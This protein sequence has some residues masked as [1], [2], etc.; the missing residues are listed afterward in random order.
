M[1]QD[2]R[3]A[4]RMILKAPA[5]SLV[6]ILTLA[7]GIGANTAIFSVVNAAM[8]RPLPFPN[9]QRLMSIFHVYKK[10]NLDRVT[11]YPAAYVYFKDHA[12]SF[13]QVAAFSGFRAPQNLTGGGDPER[14]HV[15]A[16][17]ASLFPALGT[18]PLL[19][20]AFTAE[21]DKPGAGRVAVLGYGLWNRRFGH[22]DRI[23][24]REITLDGA[25]YTV[26]GV[27]PKGFEFPEEAELWVPIAFT[28][29]Q[30]ANGS[31]YLQV[32][33]K[34]RPGVTY[35]QAQAEMAKISSEILASNGD[36]ANQ[37]GWSAATQPLQEASVSDV[38][39]ALWVLL[40]AVGCVLLI[41]CANVANLLLARAA[42]R[43][44]EIS[45]RSALGASRW[46][47]VRQL[48]SEGILLSL[49]G[50]TV[51]LLFG[52]LGLDLLLDTIPI[53]V[54]SYIR[55]EIDPAV[56][57]FTFT[58][59]IVTGIIF[60]AIPALQLTRSNVNESL[61]EG[62]RSSAA[63]TRQAVRT[64]I[65][66]AQLAFAMMLLVAAGL[67]IKTF[68][69]IQQSDF[70]FNSQ[71]LLTFRTDLPAAKYKEPAQ[72][73]A[74][75][76][77]LIERTR[78]LRG[79]T[80]AAITS[81]TPLTTNMTSIF[82]IEGKT[83]SVRPHVHVASIGSD[84]FK[85]M[86]IPVISGRPFTDADR[87]GTT[88]VA[89]IDEKTKRAYFGDEVPIGKKLTFDFEGSQEKRV[90]R[91]IVGVVGGVKHRSPLENETKGE[92][93]LPFAQE[94]EKS[95]IVAMRTTGNPLSLADAARREVLNVD[96]LQPVQ[97]LQTM[98]T[99]VDDF[100]AQ[101]RFN[102]IL[103]GT[104]GALAL[105]LSGIGVYGVMAYTVTQRTHEFGIRMALGASSA[106]VLR[107]VLNQA[108]KIT[109]VGLAVG[110]VGAF[111]A[112]RALGSMLFGV[113]ASDPATFAGI[114]LLLATI[115][116]L[117]S[118]LPARRA[119]KVDPVIAL[120]YE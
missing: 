61:K 63:S 43:Q 98:D 82:Q 109:L 76:D 70:G 12:S 52:Y 27:M 112:T 100:V 30:L 23:V 46:R 50:G 3:F 31:E 36:T 45:I 92:V 103:L 17:T 113:K 88:P 35:P 19:G 39:T 55:V 5:F 15:V 13:E 73:R 107:V 117:A 41:A 106:D 29:E 104:F 42:A 74:F 68:V 120:R 102:M 97:D 57:L 26:I 71:G 67:L 91:T 9:S 58:L 10:L 49:L 4:L 110:L 34:L 115:A 37:Y 105:I 119:T 32:I 65:V 2:F 54:P 114:A 69:R 66:V 78:N 93:F 18:P 77:Q 51:G 96:P 87:E 21:E 33:A 62:G 95:M 14:I 60:S 118:Y 116:I 56:L 48:L 86:Q 64:S 80:S 108:L 24:G 16:A 11:V 40:S 53:K 89:L 44:K 84:Y 72:I 83:F 81:E 47:V 94:A 38:R 20:R 90:W 25:N 101:P 85:T 111:A 99:V 22:D 59:A 79:V 7:L 1:I 75:Y 8:I 28:S 6:A